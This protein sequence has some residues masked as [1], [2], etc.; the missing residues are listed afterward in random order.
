[1]LTGLAGSRVTDSDV[2]RE[3][4]K[5]LNY[6]LTIYLIIIVTNCIEFYRVNWFV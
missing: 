2:E 5:K 6:K 3:P 1:M 4:S